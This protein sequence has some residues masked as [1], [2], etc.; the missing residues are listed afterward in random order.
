MFRVLFKAYQGKKLEGI[1]GF[2]E[3]PKLILSNLPYHRFLLAISILEEYSVLPERF[4]DFYLEKM[5]INLSGI[6]ALSI[7]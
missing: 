6:K 2:S 4:L 1:H 5:S 3:Q 7:S